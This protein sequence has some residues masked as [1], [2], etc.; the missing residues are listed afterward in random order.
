MPAQRQHSW[1]AII[2]TALLLT[3]GLGTLLLQPPKILADPPPQGRETLPPVE[4]A[5][6]PRPVE[7]L[8]PPWLPHYDMD[9]RL[10]LDKHKVY[11]RQRTTWTNRHQLPANELV[12]NA[13]SHYKAPASQV[14]LL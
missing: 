13:H 6:P 4:Q 5:P 1:K 11:V 12:F 10:D 9:I 14:G 2:L 3:T 7:P 8:L